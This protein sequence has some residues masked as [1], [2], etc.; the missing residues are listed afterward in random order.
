[1][2]ITELVEALEEIEHKHGDL[3]VELP[4]GTEV[5]AVEMLEYGPDG[6]VVT[7]T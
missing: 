2:T 5:S 3:D 1:M 6:W 4:D 7:L